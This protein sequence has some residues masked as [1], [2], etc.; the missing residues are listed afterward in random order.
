MKRILYL[1]SII[2]LFSLSASAQDDVYSFSTGEARPKTEKSSKTVHELMPSDKP[3]LYE[4][5]HNSIRLS[6]SLG[7]ITS[8]VYYERKDKI[9]HP[10]I[11]GLQL[12]YEHFWGEY[13]GQHGVRVTVAT[14]KAEYEKYWN[15]S[16]YHIGVAYVYSYTTTLG[17]VWS[18]SAGFGP[19]FYS[20]TDSDETG[21]GAVLGVGCEYKFNR[22]FSLGVEARYRTDRF[23]APENVKQKY[24]SRG[25]QHI[26]LLVG[27][28]FYF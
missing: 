23:H 7:E 4:P 15:F 21:F 3:Y 2:A 12:D 5:T 13:G 10:G 24:E 17:W 1:T 11:Y 14:G 6:Y 25:F 27:P 8:D 22:T 9:L 19:S 26:S 16:L 18:A 20:D 28:R